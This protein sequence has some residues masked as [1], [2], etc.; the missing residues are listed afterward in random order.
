MDGGFFLSGIEREEHEALVEHVQVP[1]IAH[2]PLPIPYPYMEADAETWIQERS[3]HR[4]EQPAEVTFALRTPERT[5][6]GVVG[7]DDL[8]VSSLHRANVGDWL[9][10]RC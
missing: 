3:A 7:A 10:K 8:E 6:I 1:Q 4:R 5:L 9:S 2:N